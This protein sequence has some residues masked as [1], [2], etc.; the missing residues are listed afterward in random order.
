MFPLPNQVFETAFALL[1]LRTEEDIR[2]QLL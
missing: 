2:T 1:Y